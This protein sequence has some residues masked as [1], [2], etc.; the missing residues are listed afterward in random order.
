MSKNRAAVTL[1]RRGGAVTGGAKAC[2]A[3][4]N[5]AKGGRPRVT[6]YACGACWLLIAKGDDGWKNWSCP[7]H[8]TARV[9]S[10]TQT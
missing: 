5:G 6:H 10:I 3:R 8:P 7:E 9:V 2:A 1:G 4:T